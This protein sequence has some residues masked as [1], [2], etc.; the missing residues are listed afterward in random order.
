MKWFKKFNRKVLLSSDELIIK[1]ITADIK[2]QE[3]IDILVKKVHEL[4]REVIQLKV[5]VRNLKHELEDTQYELKEGKY[6]Y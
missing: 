4:G 1:L 6:D 5:D 3:D 2:R